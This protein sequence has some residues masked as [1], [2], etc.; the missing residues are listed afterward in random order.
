MNE[1]AVNIS[2]VM[3]ALKVIK[4]VCAAQHCC[5]DCPFYTSDRC[6]IKYEDPACW[7]LTSNYTWRA[8]K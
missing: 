5:A 7:E 1:N 2:E 3:S 6:N 4:D 8:F